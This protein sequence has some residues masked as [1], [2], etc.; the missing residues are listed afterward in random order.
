MTK[1]KSFSEFH[2]ELQK[3]IADGNL[4]RLFSISTILFP[5]IIKNVKIDKFMSGEII[6]DDLLYSA[7][8]TYN[9]LR[10]NDYENLWRIL[11]EDDPNYEKIQSTSTSHQ[12][13]WVIS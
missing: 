7:T 9:K 3:A 6:D 13:N 8:N 11:Y 5:G 10:F 2:K 12:L 4:T 1:R